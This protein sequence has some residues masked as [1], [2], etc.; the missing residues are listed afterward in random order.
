MGVDS[1]LS[2]SYG[3]NHNFSEIDLFLLIKKEVV[4]MMRGVEKLW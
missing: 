3:K 4:N 2:V 1:V